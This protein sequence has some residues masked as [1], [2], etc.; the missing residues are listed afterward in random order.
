MKLK[1]LILFSL[2]GLVVALDQLTKNLAYLNLAPGEEL[3]LIGNALTLV[4]S[5]NTGFAFGLILRAP[6]SVR[7]VFFVG[8]PV[9]ALVLIVM[10]FIKLQDDEMLTSVALT[11]LL[12]GALGNLIDRVQYGHV[13]DFLRLRLFGF[14]FPP[15]N[16]ADASIIIGVIL[17]VINTFRRTATRSPTT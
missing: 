13:L 17:M 16:I 5:H 6:D 9:F 7:D 4:L 11:T 2:S 10:I 14:E 8:I 3:S 15:F 1:Y 12:A